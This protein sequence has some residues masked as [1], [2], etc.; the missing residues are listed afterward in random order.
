MNSYQ[1]ANFENTISALSALHQVISKSRPF[2]D[3]IIE[4]GWV[5]PDADFIPE[6]IIARR[7][8]SAMIM[9]IV[10]AESLLFV[11]PL[12]INFVKFEN[13]WPVFE[14]CQFSNKVTMRIEMAGY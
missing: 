2:T 7:E 6:L 9:D 14:H 8:L 10:P 1:F 12:E 5:N 4:A 3:Y 11:S 13:D